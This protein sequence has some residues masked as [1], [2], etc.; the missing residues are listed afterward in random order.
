MIKLPKLPYPDCSRTSNSWQWEMF[1]DGLDC[2]G[3]QSFPKT[4]ITNQNMPWVMQLFSGSRKSLQCPQHGKTAAE[5]FRAQ[6]SLPSAGGRGVSA[7]APSPCPSLHR[8]SWLSE[9]TEMLQ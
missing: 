9:T 3:C 5:I 4:S 7:E 6:E 1:T 8:D 2:S